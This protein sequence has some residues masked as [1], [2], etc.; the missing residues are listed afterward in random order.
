MEGSK[1]AVGLASERGDGASIYCAGTFSQVG[2]VGRCYNPVITPFVIFV[3]AVGCN[4]E[5][6]GRAMGEQVG[7][8]VKF[9]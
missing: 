9:V 4:K 1:D 5:V 6:R 8:G 2:S 7:T 3:A